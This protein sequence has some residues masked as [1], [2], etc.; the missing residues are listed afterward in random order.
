MSWDE[1]HDVQQP[2]GYNQP[3]EDGFDGWDWY[4]QK[5]EELLHGIWDM[6]LEAFSD[7][8]AGFPL[9]YPMTRLGKAIDKAVDELVDKQ[10][11]EYI[12]EHG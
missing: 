3:P 7:E 6:S 9:L 10:M 12:S 5:K 1:V 11:E 4:E 8:M 2:S